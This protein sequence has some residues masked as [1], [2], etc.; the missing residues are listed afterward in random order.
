MPPKIIKLTK[1]EGIPS[2]NKRIKNLPED[3]VVFELGA[4]HPLLSNSN[5]L[6]LLKRAG[7]VAGKD[8]KVKVPENDEM[9]KILAHKAG[10]LY[11][12]V[13]VNLPR[14]VRQTVK[15]A[16]S[17]VKPNFSDIRGGKPAVHK[18]EPAEKFSLPI[19]VPSLDKLVPKISLK[20]P[21]VNAKRYFIA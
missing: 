6:K 19:S 13:E 18:P 4:G 5:N 20:K 16:R 15:V 10:V 2:V 1:R 14:P 3:E 17:D 12:D 7:E 9:A 21:S 8:I 11:G